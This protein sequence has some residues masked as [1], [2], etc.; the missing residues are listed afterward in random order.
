[1]QKCREEDSVLVNVSSN[2]EN[3]YL[4]RRHNGAKSWLGLNYR[5]G[6]FTW[7]DRGEGNFTAWA[8]NQPNNF[9]GEGCVHALGVKNSYEW[10]VVQCSESHPYTCKKGKKRIPV[11]WSNRPFYSCLLS[12]LAFEWQLTLF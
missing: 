1:M 8:K 11:I 10:I 4:Q 7:V 12:D 2:E 9:S 6:N 5:Q 3:V